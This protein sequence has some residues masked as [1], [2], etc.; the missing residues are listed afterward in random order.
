[1]EGADRKGE[2]AGKSVDATVVRVVDGDT[3]QMELDDGGEEGV[4]FIG[5][6]TPESVAPGQPVECFGKKA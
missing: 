3:A 2:P 6:D 4:R 1:M 5:V